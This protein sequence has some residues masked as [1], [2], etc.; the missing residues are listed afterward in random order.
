VNHPALVKTSDQP[1]FNSSN[2][3]PF[4]SAEALRASDISP[5]P[6]LYLQPNTRG[7]TTKKITSSSYRKF[8]GATQKKKIK[9]GTKLKTNQLA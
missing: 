8:V 9:R 6:S 5:V 1:L 3:S 7:G 4:T 2:F